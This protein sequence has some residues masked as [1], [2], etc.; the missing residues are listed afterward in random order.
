MNFRSLGYFLDFLIYFK[1]RKSFTA[2]ALRHADLSRST[3]PVQ[4]KEH[5]VP[6]CL[7]LAID[8]NLYGLMVALSLFEGFVHWLFLK[9]MYWFQGVYELT[10]VLLRN[11]LKIGH[12]SVELIA[13]MF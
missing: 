5:A 6:P 12:V 11:Y 13:S 9:S 10:K 8:D 1:S 4:V 2:S 3:D 7:V